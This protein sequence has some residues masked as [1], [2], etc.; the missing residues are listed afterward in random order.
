MQLGNVVGV[1]T[2]TLK[3]TLKFENVQK[4]TRII[5][6]IPNSL[7]GRRLRLQSCLTHRQL[8]DGP[9]QLIGE[10]GL[11]YT[12]DIGILTVPHHRN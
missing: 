3:I 4:R 1:L 6:S 9:P 11:G 12:H 8:I 5:L 10:G 7:T 2:Q